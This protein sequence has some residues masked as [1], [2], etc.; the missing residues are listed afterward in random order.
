M[1]QERYILIGVLILVF[2]A[3]VGLIV[4]AIIRGPD[5]IPFIPITRTTPLSPIYPKGTRPLT[6]VNP[7][8]KPINPLPKPL[9]PIA[10]AYTLFGFDIDIDMSGNVVFSLETD[11]QLPNTVTKAILNVNSVDFYN[12]DINQAVMSSLKTNPII[13]ITSV[14]YHSATFESPTLKQAIQNQGFEASHW[15]GYKLVA[16]IIV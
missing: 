9:T 2:G 16:D 6:P 3:I 7:P 10:K 14:S 4:W 15:S 1:D 8:M 12:Q 13:N 5:T 11:A